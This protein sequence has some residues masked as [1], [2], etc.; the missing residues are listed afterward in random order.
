MTHPPLM[1]FLG[2]PDD[3]SDVALL[4]LPGAIEPSGA[5]VRAALKERLRYLDR[6]PGGS[7]D[8]AVIVRNALLEAALR[9]AR[10]DGDDP[11]VLPDDAPEVTSTPESVQVGTTGGLLQITDFDREI[12]SI[13]VGCGGWNATSRGHLVHLAARNGVSPA[14]FMRIAQGLSQLLHGGGFDDVLPGT[15][16]RPR[17][18]RPRQ[19]SPEAG[20]SGS[21]DVGAEPAALEDRDRT[22]TAV[23]RAYDPH[24]ERLVRD[25]QRLYWGLYLFSLLLVLLL[26]GVVVLVPWSRLG[27]AFVGGSPSQSE[28]AVVSGDQSPR[29]V[30]STPGA[31][32]ADRATFQTVPGVDPTA[33]PWRDYP[34]FGP[35]EPLPRAPA[36]LELLDW[37]GELDRLAEDV[38]QV[39]N[40][41]T[42]DAV[43]SFEDLLLRCGTVWPLMDRSLRHQLA[44]SCREPLIAASDYELRERLLGVFTRSLAQ[45]DELRKPEDLWVGSWITGILGTLHD[46]PDQPRQLREQVRSMLPSR[47]RGMVSGSVG[48][49]SSFAGNASRYLDRSFS[50]ILAR[51]EDDDPSAARSLEFWLVAQESLLEGV[52]YH[53]MLLDCIT[54]VLEDAALDSDSGGT[55]LLARLISELDRS[56]DGLDSQL[57][58]MNLQDWFVSPRIR[59]RGLRV[60]TGL[61]H[62]SGHLPWW[63][64]SL[65]LMPDAS[66]EQRGALLVRI[67]SA[68]PALDRTA[69]SPGVPITIEDRRRLDDLLDTT[70]SQ[71]RGDLER[72]R[73]LLVVGHVSA[74]V[75]AFWK[76]APLRA[77]KH[78]ADAE[79]LL[80]KPP[81]ADG[82]HDSVRGTD[83][84]TGADPGMGVD[85]RFLVDGSWTVVWENARNKVSARKQALRE[86]GQFPPS[87]DI[88]LVDATTL[89]RAAL[90]SHPETRALAQSIILEEFSESPSILVGLLNTV[91]DRPSREV[92]EFFSRLLVEEPLPPRTS[93]AWPSR[94][95][96][97]LV[98]QS[99]LRQ[100]SELH[101]IDNLATRY[102]T[103]LMERLE[104]VTDGEVAVRLNEP[105]EDLLAQHADHLRDRMIDSPSAAAIP[106]SLDELD[107][108]R[109]FHHSRAT[110]S[111][112]Q[113]VVELIAIADL[114]AFR[115]AQ[116][117]PDLHEQLRKH[118]SNLLFKLD[119]AMN[120]LEQMILLEQAIAHYTDL[121]LEVEEGGSA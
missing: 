60:L 101:D 118:H 46:D 39:P 4:G 70:R 13:L 22:R 72:M 74:A 107:R 53:S 21:S 83:P 108:K 64:E 37:A 79:G 114:C 121:R 28:Q 71:V 20:A 82:I 81:I 16:R 99:W 109:L 43:R 116:L 112:E 31:R 113:V 66:D 18:A 92:H 2:L 6:H 11:P 69:R 7:E 95:R 14:S 50:A 103:L 85:H 32:A 111:L 89:A 29:S 51:A 63:S 77:R 110:S 106:A 88:G 47:T 56:V 8:E 93:P 80:R 17:S 67:E 58:R 15:S 73:R 26:V 52:L 19:A 75:E 12:L 84:N 41:A 117:R 40:P 119:S 100:Q 62:A 55:R 27:S 120:I 38:H 68:W 1:R 34:S 78:L 105:P 104:S 44:R 90:K 65:I 76:D 42:E 57:V 10:A 96:T 9:L 48:F 25:D 59:A 87:N 23:K 98:R 45:A 3:A 33:S 115:T 49:H 24:L 54:L 94:V 102:A 35:I 86:L 36:P 61:L 30:R 97:A 5:V 91:T